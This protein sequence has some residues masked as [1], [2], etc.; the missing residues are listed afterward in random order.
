M[1]HMRTRVWI[2]GVVAACL[3]YGTVANAQA[4]LPHENHYKVY[5][6]ILIPYV[7][8]VGLV[9]QFG[10]ITVDHFTLEKFANPT[11]KI[12]VDGTV[13][14][15]VDPLIHQ[16]WW[17]IDV[18]QPART[19]VGID[20]FGTSQWHLRDAKYLLNP[21]LKN[22]LPGPGGEYPPPPVWNHYVCYDALGPTVGKPVILVDQFGQT[23]VVV[24]YGKLFCNPAEKRTTDATGNVHVDPIID[25]A[26]HLACYVTQDATPMTRSITA[27][28][29]FGYWQLETFDSDCLCVPALKEHVIGTEE[30]TWGRIK[31]MYR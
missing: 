11:E 26:A 28:D 21:A 22:V 9:D 27:V 14:P 4:T 23:N 13:S 31:A 15:I 29:Q 2:L 25:Y 30:S 12:H 20:Q 19:I 17:R 18:P 1:E 8:P 3:M 24:V 6:T 16:T 7:K 5:S 10:A